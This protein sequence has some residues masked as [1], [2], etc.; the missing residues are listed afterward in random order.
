MLSQEG[1][2]R[3]GSQPSMAGSRE[4]GRI[5]G[6][7]VSMGTR[8]G[9]QVA[10]GE[11]D[12][13]V[14]STLERGRLM[15]VPM[16]SVGKGTV[17]RA[18]GRLPGGEER[19]SGRGVAPGLPF[20]WLKGAASLHSADRPSAF[21]RACALDSSWETGRVEHRTRCREPRVVAPPGAACRRAP[22]GP[23]ALPHGA[24]GW[25]NALS[26]EGLEAG[27]AMKSRTSAVSAHVHQC[28]QGAPQQASGCWAA[29]TPRRCSR[30]RPC[31][32][33]TMS[34]GTRPRSRRSPPSS[35]VSFLWLCN[36]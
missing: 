25:E 3:L 33:E 11:T 6:P 2:F 13:C 22:L 29:L 35:G 8:G 30:L 4:S 36:K 26:F 19:F 17:N 18:E 32:S 7:R 12:S 23:A 27:K 20:F 16:A 28:H 5:Q 24:H 9:R 10:D 21:D 14:G 1:T 31:C 34:W 15:A